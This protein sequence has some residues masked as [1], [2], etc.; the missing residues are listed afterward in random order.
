MVI[1]LEIRLHSAMGYSPPTREAR[2]PL[3]SL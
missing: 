2:V 1:K 3:V